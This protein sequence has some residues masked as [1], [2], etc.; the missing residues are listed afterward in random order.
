MHH[1]Q[2][3]RKSLIR[4]LLDH[5]IYL[6][7]DVRKRLS[8]IRKVE[9]GLNLSTALFHLKALRWIKTGKLD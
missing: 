8:L 5:P 3:E 6:S 9:E 7:M 1:P 2:G 4:S